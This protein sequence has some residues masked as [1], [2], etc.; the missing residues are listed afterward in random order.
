MIVR[1]RKPSAVNSCVQ[2]ATYQQFLMNTLS[3]LPI[4]AAPGSMRPAWTQA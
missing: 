3:P 2:L 4:E 1:A